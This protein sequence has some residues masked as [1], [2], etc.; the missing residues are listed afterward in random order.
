VESFSDEVL[1]L[2][3]DGVLKRGAP[4]RLQPA[5]RK[6]RVDVLQLE[7]MSESLND[8]VPSDDPCRLVVKLIALLDLKSVKNSLPLVG[9][10]SYPLE[11]MLALVMFAMW[12]GEYGSRRVEKR[13]KFDNRYRWICQGFTPDHTTI[14]RFRRFI[15]EEID[16]LLADSVRLG[17]EA[18]LE[19]L[20]R[21]S[22][23][24]TKLPGAASQWRKFRNAF[25][26]AD[27]ALESN[28]EQDDDCSSGEPLEPKEFSAVEKAS[29]IIDEFKKGKRNRE[30]L[31]CSDPE[32]RTL[33]GRQGNF[34]VGYNPSVLVDRDTDLISAFYMSNSASDSAL[35]EPALEKYFDIYDEF[36]N[37]LLADAGFDTPRNAHV[38]AELGIDAYVSCKERTPFWRL[39]ENDQLLCPMGYIP[40]YDVNFLRKGISVNRYVVHECSTCKLRSKCLKEENSKPKSISFDSIAN[41]VHWIRQKHKAKSE[42][43]KAKLKERGETI[44]F[45]FARMKQRFG[46]RRLS[47]W[48]LKGAAI[49]FGIVALAMN[50]A[51]IAAKTGHEGLEALLTDLLL[52]VCAQARFLK[53]SFFA[54]RAILGRITS[55]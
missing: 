40:K 51:I 8:L 49:E 10:P 28:D 5:F 44:E 27:I 18:G 37:D 3:P 29:A 1:D 15:G 24:G 50:L 39:D 13:C 19:S 33:K 41:P 14:W 36:P 17:K 12:D 21:A 46:F 31:P 26:D 43:G 4:V 25:D 38:L 7:L 6:S 34:I 42:D 55:S 11:I 47:M 32:A 52:A 45:G 30:P 22:L 23:D 2:V 35:L 9:A 54:S 53:H 16:S 48:G 20:G